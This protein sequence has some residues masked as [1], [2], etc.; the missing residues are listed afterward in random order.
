MKIEQIILRNIQRHK[1]L[2]IDL[3]RGSNAVLGHNNAGK[4]SIIRACHWLLKNAP[5]GDWMCRKSGD[6]I[7]EASIK[8]VFDDGSY[9]VR[10]NGPKQGNVYKFNDQKFSGFGRSIPE[11]ILEHIG[12]ITIDLGTAE[13]SPC[14]SR[15]IPNEP[16]FLLDETAPTRGSILNY[17]TGIDI[18]DKIKRELNKD[19]R[20]SKKET[21]WLDSKINGVEEELGQYDGIDLLSKRVLKLKREYAEYQELVGKLEERKQ[22]RTKR[23]K[24]G[25]S[26]KAEKKKV[27][28]LQPLVRRYS[29]L[30]QLERLLRRLTGT[31]NQLVGLHKV[32]A[33][34]SRVG[35]LKTTIKKV[36]LAEGLL[37]E[38][39]RVKTMKGRVKKLEEKL[40]EF[41]VCP[42]CGRPL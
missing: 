29:N 40:Q 19:I 17:L 9:I 13:I 42:E 1:R 2:V 7:H 25:K 3:D 12:K 8:M 14:L 30:V 26:I 5:L 20:A 22:L 34:E 33:M 18:A 10:S 31:S 16:P 21:K 41:D 28:L 35:M 15:C 4:S 38:D 11:P 36:E 23:S 39:K 37:R 6:K 32:V 27:A 24:L